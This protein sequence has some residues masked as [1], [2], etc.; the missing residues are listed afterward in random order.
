[1]IRASSSHPYQRG[2]GYADRDVL[3]VFFGCLML[4]GLP[5]GQSPRLP[6]NPYVFHADRRLTV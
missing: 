6:W 2:I 5:C 3:P 1:M 4:S